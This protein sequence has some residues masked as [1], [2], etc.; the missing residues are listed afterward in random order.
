MWN[1]PATPF[2]QEARGSRGTWALPTA[3]LS[4]MTLLKISSCYSLPGP[5]SSSAV[6]SE[7]PVPPAPPGAVTFSLFP[8]HR[9]AVIPECAVTISPPHAPGTMVK[10]GVKAT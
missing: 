6:A 3:V 1:P 8:S 9:P 2:P 10:A 7:Q 4:L 5:V